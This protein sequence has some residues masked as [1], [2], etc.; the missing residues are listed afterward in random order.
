M[1]YNDVQK[2]E[3]VANYLLRGM[4][5]TVYQYKPYNELDKLLVSH[6]QAVSINY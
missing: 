4:I 6:H 2:H 5:N 3:N 1:A